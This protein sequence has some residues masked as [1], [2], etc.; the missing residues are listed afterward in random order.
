MSRLNLWYSARIGSPASWGSPT[1]D[2]NKIRSWLILSDLQIPFED[3]KTLRA[4]EK[5]MAAHTWAGLLYIGDFMDFDFIS[6]F[7]DQN[8][9]ATANRTFK[10]DYAYAN[11]ILDRHQLLIWENNPYAKFVMLEGNHEERVE[12]FLDAN[13]K[14]Q[15]SVEVENGLRLKERGFEWIRSWSKGELYRIG[16]ATFTHG[17][18]TNQYHAKK[19]VDAYGSS[20]F[21]GHTH[22]VMEIPRTHKGK[23]DIIVGQSIGCLC[24][25]EQSYMKGKPSNWQQAFMVLHLLPNGNYTYYI[26]RI[27]D[28]QFVGTDGVLYTP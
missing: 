20:I 18:Y 15:G 8:L 24:E 21:Y 22:D 17:L 1:T 19:M 9:R 10:Q 2:L 13:P 4:V 11:K 3:P 7:N 12:R 14:M 5:Y 27:I 6:S 25:Y 23:Q 26:T 28:H 16:K